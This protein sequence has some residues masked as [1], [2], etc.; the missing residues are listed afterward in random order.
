MLS[1]P[2][3]PEACRVSRPSERFG[4]GG[5]LVRD[6]EDPAALMVAQLRLVGVARAVAEALRRR[7]VLDDEVVPVREPDRAVGSDLRVDGCEPLLRPGRQI[8]AVARHEARALLLDDA[9][10]D[11]VRSRFVDER[12]AIP[13]LARERPRRVEVVTGAAVWPLNTSTCRMCGVSGCTA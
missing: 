3:A 5:V 1:E 11:Q 2:S 4:A 12:D 9:L 13:V 10:P 6:P 7:V 8:P